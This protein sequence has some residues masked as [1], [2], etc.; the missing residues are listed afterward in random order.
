[1][2]RVLGR[3]TSGN[4]QKV[5]WLLEEMGELEG[6]RRRQYAECRLQ[7]H[8]ADQDLEYGPNGLEHGFPKRP[9][10][11]VQI[12][13]SLLRHPPRKRGS[14]ASGK[15]LRMGPGFPLSRE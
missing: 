13:C 9:S 3:K 10:T 7:A 12:G 14:R 2:L 6:N 8:D 5:I 1:M 11:P 4:V 15:M